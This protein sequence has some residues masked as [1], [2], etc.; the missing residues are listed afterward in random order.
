MSRHY[1]FAPAHRAAGMCSYSELARRIAVRE[2]TVWK[3]VS[4]GRIPE[5]AAD[6]LAV[7]L[8]LHPFDIWT[9]W[10][11]VPLER[12]EYEAMDNAARQRCRRKARKS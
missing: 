8:G 5:L 4:R 12:L 9:E 1:D 10:F 6:R 7:A 11:D 3:W 2:D